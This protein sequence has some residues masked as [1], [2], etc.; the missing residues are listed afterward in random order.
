M[1]TAAAERTGGEWFP[2]VARCGALTGAAVLAAGLTEVSRL[3]PSAPPAINLLTGFSVAVYLLAPRDLWW[4]IVLVLTV[5]GLLCGTAAESLSGRLVLS[6]GLQAGSVLLALVLLRIGP[7]VGTLFGS[8]GIPQLVSRAAAAAGLS[9][10]LSLPWW[11][12][13]LPYLDPSS[14]ALTAT[15]LSHVLGVLFLTPLAF[16]LRP[17]DRVRM[18]LLADW[19]SLIYWGCVILLGS[20]IGWFATGAV[21]WVLLPLGIIFTLQSWAGLRLA[22]WVGAIGMLLLTITLVIPP[23]FSAGPLV[24]SRGIP[25]VWTVE[26]QLFLLSAGLATLLGSNWVVG[27]RAIATREARYRTVVND[28]IDLIVRWR[29]DGAVLFA[30]SAC[31]AFVS[32]TGAAYAYRGAD[33]LPFADVEAVLSVVTRLSPESPMERSAQYAV[34]NDDHPVWLEWTNRGF[35]DHSGRLV[36]IQSVGRDV[37][38]RKSLEDLMQERLRFDELLARTGRLFL[39][40]ERGNYESALR[41]ALAELGSDLGVDRLRL[42]ELVDESGAWRVLS[43]YW[44]AGLTHGGD[45]GRLKSSDLWNSA[46]WLAEQTMLGSTVVVKRLDDLPAS[47][48]EERR[49]L[50]QCSVKSLLQVPL[51]AGGKVL[52]AL[53]AESLRT[54]RTWTAG[55]IDRIRLIGGLFADVLARSRYESSL[56]FREEFERLIGDASSRLVNCDA[57]RIPQEIERLLARIGVFLQTDRCQ[58]VELID[59][60][61]AAVRRS[62]WC[63]PGIE[64][65]SESG[66]RLL[67]GDFLRLAPGFSP[68]GIRQIPRAGDLPDEEAE[69]RRVLT[70]N[71]V[72]SVVIIPVMVEGEPIGMLT[73]SSLYRVREWPGDRLPLMAMLG[74]LLGHAVQRERTARSLDRQ[75]E[76]LALAS[77]LSVMGEMAAGIAHDVKQPLHAIRAFSASIERATSAALLPNGVA[78]AGPDKLAYWA[79]RISELVDRADGIVCKYRDFCRSSPQE[80]ET[81]PASLPVLDSL[82]LLQVEIQERQVTVELLLEAHLPQIVG[83]RIQLQQVFVNLFKNACDELAEVAT[84]RRQITVTG[85]RA[86]QGGEEGVQFSVRDFGRGIGASAADQLFTLFFTTKPTGTGLGL[87]ICQ[88]IVADHRGHIW[89]ESSDPGVTFHVWLPC[90]AETSP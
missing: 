26:L 55:E 6:A 70:T 35:F 24:V 37:S 49:E 27:T 84:E 66:Q 56:R 16:E 10:L 64:P 53:Y 43:E 32:A 12:Q 14:F 78:P 74:D 36:E 9:I 57:R 28:Q 13:L 23:H 42:V 25:A 80:R 81:L 48:A 69:L 15:V 2:A 41:E 89:Y 5:S 61:Q 34:L 46:G 17:F 7:G 85:R 88:T 51:R 87:A 59:G 38:S 71:G 72:Q 39:D 68:A 63:A 3:T 47:A 67:E 58:F 90:A 54:E 21:P 75:R 60:K 45:W 73:L 8:H 62:E 50:E 29:P 44:A 11:R 76:D 40:A 1:E 33:R 19:E 79:G 22:T 86:V 65:L 30:N 82:A 31:R 4:R 52:G 77:R 18:Q 20:G 83:D